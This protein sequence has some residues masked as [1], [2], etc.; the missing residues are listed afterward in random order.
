MSEITV[1]TTSQGGYWRIFVRPP[2]GTRQDITWFRDVPTQI[3]Q[4]STTDPFGDSVATMTVPGIT[5][6]DRPGT[7]TLKWLQPKAD[8]DFIWYDEND[9]PTTY[10][11][12][13]FIVSEEIAGAGLN[14]QL[15]GALYQLDDFLAAPFY[16]QYPVPYE[17]LIQNAFDPLKHP[18]LRTSALVINFPAGWTKVV[19][20]PDQT[21]YLWFLR[22]WGVKPGDLWTGLTTRDTGGWNQL[23]TGQVQTLLSV[24]YTD[25]GGQWTVYKRTGRVPV[26]QVRPALRYPSSTTLEVYY[27][28][29]GVDVSASR[30]FTQS[31]NVIFGSGTDLAGSSFSGQ[32]ITADGQTTYYEPF[33]ALPQYYPS[34]ATNPRL[35]TS[36][37]RKEAKV[38]FATGLDEQA[39][40]EVANT[41]LR[42][43]ADPGY[44]GSITL[45][46]DPL[47]SGQPFP[48]QL[49]RAGQTIVLRGFRGTDVLFHISQASIDVAQE[50]ATLTVDSK[51]RDALTVAEVQARTRDA[52]DPVHLLKAGA[53]ELTVQDEILPWS[54]AEGSGVI[55][56]D[57]KTYDARPFFKN[58]PLGMKFPWTEWTKKYPPSNP[59]YAKYYIP[60]P[61]ANVVA[62][63]NWSGI[64]RDGL[65]SMGI[66]IKMS[67]QGSI[68]LAQ[69]AAYDKNG[70]V[71]PVRFHVGIYS[72]SGTN[73]TSMPMIPAKY[74]K[75]Y[76]GS[77][78]G[79]GYKAGERYPFY[80]GAFEN[81]NADGTIT[82]NPGQLLAQGTTMV[83]GWGNFYEGAGY[84]PGTQGAGAAKSGMLV[85]EV[86]W[87]FSTMSAGT[88]F[89]QYSVTRTRSSANAGQLYIL[90]YC[91][92]QGTQPVY[93]LGR[94]FRQEPGGK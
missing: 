41:Q 80:P 3:Q 31:A 83:M 39:A 49:I 7:G 54:Y 15:K 60:I 63:K 4:M 13:G 25:D 53:Y 76:K 47:L 1:R 52:L 23:L 28:A 20:S 40:R 57:P 71:V 66:P 8:V 14:L 67:Q 70:N 78:G 55:P 77:A 73:V 44:T 38:T 68:R 19:P 62:T 92:D 26:L 65:S 61:K 45:K 37:A 27:G 17:R 34:D 46:T 10:T 75:K 18:S 59:S 91:D 22:P 48:R 64:S 56:S 79:T 85:D 9:R 36:L 11:W 89:D 12:E 6:F 33:A 82:D 32:Q 87:P 88:D 93:F 90:I 69:I 86:V 81:Q 5:G 16:P 2:G 84:D 42:R 51:F 35:M 30:D 72:T 21:E 74:D 29:H 94:F 58:M 50:T 43:F 24:M